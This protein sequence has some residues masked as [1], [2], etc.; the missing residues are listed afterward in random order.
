LYIS[1]A[2]TNVLDKMINKF[3][4]W[5]FDLDDNEID[6]DSDTESEPDEKIEIKMPISKLKKD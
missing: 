5:K 4:L 6:I 2:L 1:E 3:D